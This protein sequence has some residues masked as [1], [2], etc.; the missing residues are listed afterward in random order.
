VERGEIE[1]CLKIGRVVEGQGGC[2]SRHINKTL[3]DKLLNGWSI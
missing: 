1:L 3:A 2:D